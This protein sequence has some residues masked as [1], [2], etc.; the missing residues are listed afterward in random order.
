MT[1]LQQNARQLLVD[2]FSRHGRM[3]AQR[4]RTGYLTSLATMI[5]INALSLFAS[6]AL[7][8]IIGAFGVAIAVFVVANVAAKRH[9]DT[10][11]LHVPPI[12]P[13]SIFSSNP[14]ANQNGR[15]GLC[16]AG[17]FFMAM[18]ILHL[19]HLEHNKITLQFF[20]ATFFVGSVA[21][22]AARYL[23]VAP[24]YPGPNQY[25]PNPHEVTP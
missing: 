24:S 2:L 19:V 22:F 11:P 16:A 25:G 12:N 10:S 3:P 9:R 15:S 6:G 23:W 5:V 17:L 18:S 21:T 8:L 20:A 13:F 7:S 1:A 4:F 14:F